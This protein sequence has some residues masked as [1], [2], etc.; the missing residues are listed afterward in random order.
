M[1]VVIIEDE[2]PAAAR[3]Q[4]ML[5]ATASGVEVLAVLDT[6]SGATAWLRANPA[7]DLIFMDIQ[8]S[9]GLSLDLVKTMKIGCPVIFVTAY[10]AY[11]QEAFGCHGIDYLLKPVK[12]ERLEAALRKLDEIREYFMARYMGLVEKQGVKGKF[13]VRRGSEFVSIRVEEI[14]FFYASHKLVCLVRKD[15]AKFIL[16]QSLAEI[17]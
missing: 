13:L 1:K 8:L 14:S 16:D 15:G 4:K 3:L 2:A 9:D 11:W 7:P 17:E 6:L 5:A 12:Q 10:D